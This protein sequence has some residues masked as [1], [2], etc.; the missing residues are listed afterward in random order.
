MLVAGAAFAYLQFFR[1][2]PQTVEATLLPQIAQPGPDPTSSDGAVGA[3]AATVEPADEGREAVLEVSTDGGWEEQATA[4]QDADGRV[5]FLLP[6]DGLSAGTSYRV[7]SPGG[8]GL[9]AATS[10]TL[11]GDAWGD[12]TFGDEFDGEDDERRL[13][14]PG[15]GLQPRRP[16]GVLPGLR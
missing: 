12:A 1:S 2:S 15:R 14:Q 8:D 10:A 7:S 13:G 3:V 16:Q 6:A 9:D 5:E 4:E 11:A